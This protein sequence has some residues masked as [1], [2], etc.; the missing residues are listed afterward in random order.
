MK[1]L[2]LF[3]AATL[4]AASLF[5]G[6]SKGANYS[7]YIS[8]KRSNIYLY[9]NDGISI[10]IYCSEKEQPFSADGYRGQ[11]NPTT[12]IFVTLSSV[13]ESVEAS[14]AGFGG[15]MNYMS[16]DKCFYLAF[17]AED[18]GV[19]SVD[20]TLTYGGKSETYGVQSVK[21]EGVLTCE[22]AL[23]C[24]REYD[25]ELFASLTDGKLFDGEIFVRLLY[26]DGCF[27]YVGVCDKNKTISAFLIDGIKGRIISTKTLQG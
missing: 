9:E 11:I 6:C 8:D 20:V 15:E 2:L 22:Q 26:D 18:F 24:A 25:G 1:K 12:E 27:Y 23:D 16:V 10:K 3:A 4:A 13:P 14:V 17:T 7:D 5:S 21:Q 19:S